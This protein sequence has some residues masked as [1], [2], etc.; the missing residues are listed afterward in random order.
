MR[1]TLFA[2]ALL[3]SLFA[4]NGQ[5]QTNPY[6]TP[7]LT[8]TGQ[9]VMGEQITFSLCAPEDT[10]VCIMFSLSDVPTPI[11]GFNMTSIPIGMPLLSNF[12]GVISSELTCVEAS[13][14]IPCAP[15]LVGMEVFYWAFGVDINNPTVINGLAMDSI[16][17]QDPGD[18]ASLDVTT[19]EDLNGNG[20]RD[21]GEP[22]FANVA[23]ELLCAGPDALFYTG[24]DVVLPFGTDAAGKA[25]LSGLGYGD[26]MVQLVGGNPA[27]YSQT[28]GFMTFDLATCEREYLAIGFGAAMTGGEGLTPGYW[29]QS[30]HFFAWTAPLTPSTLFSD[31]F[32][33]AF[34]GMTLLQVLQQGGGGL[35]ALGRHTVAALLNAMN[36]NIAYLYTPVEVINMFDTALPG[37]DYTTLKNDFEA[38]NQL[39]A[40]AY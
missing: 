11:T 36:A 4:S 34:P 39:G 25:L 31:V 40:A 9:P 29:K 12:D 26:C 30:Q 16:I 14:V 37:S 21:P 3:V 22:D 13:T 38:Q 20:L 8:I 24:D 32:A 5:A 28:G 15:F 27:G 2:L 7:T 18:T 33:D 1:R 17:I 19:Y 6:H 10:F 35:N 23:L